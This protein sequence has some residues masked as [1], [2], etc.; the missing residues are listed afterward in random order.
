[1]A[2]E[3][4]FKDGTQ[5]SSTQYCEDQALTIQHGHTLETVQGEALCST[6]KTQVTPGS[7]T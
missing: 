7:M 1:M 4:S 5:N 6:E 3:I 2:E